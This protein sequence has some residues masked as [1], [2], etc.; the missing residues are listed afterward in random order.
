MNDVAPK[1]RQKIFKMFESEVKTAGEKKKNRTRKYLTIV[2][3]YKKE[4]LSSKLPKS[5]FVSNT[6][7]M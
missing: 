2:V 5:L 6:K 4:Q 3:E 7:L 1:K